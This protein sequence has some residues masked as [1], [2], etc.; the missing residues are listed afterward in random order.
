MLAIDV[1]LSMQSTDVAPTRIASRAD[2]GEGVRQ[3]APDRVQRRSGRRSPRPPN[4]LVSPSK[5]RE[6]I[7]QAIDGLQLPRRR[8]PA[9][10]CSPA[11]PRSRPCRR[12]AR[13]ALRRPGS[14]CS[15]TDTARPVGRSRTRPRRLQAANSPGFDDRVRHR[16][17]HRRHRWR[18]PA[19]AGRPALVA[20]TRRSRPR[21]T[22][23]RRR[24]LT[25]L[26]QVYQDMGSSIGYKTVPT[27]ITQWYVGDRLAVRVRRSRDEP[28]LD[29]TDAV[30]PAA[31]VSGRDA[32]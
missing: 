20:A 19:G 3:D 11:W 12:T 21:G 8:R 9:R 26:K 30:T 28:A 4:V 2:G 29:V 27:E 6:A 16:Q 22:S 1:S 23:T 31:T 5:D 25:A 24:S 17:R 15:R 14:C 7:T 32:S 13:P 10:L 18:D